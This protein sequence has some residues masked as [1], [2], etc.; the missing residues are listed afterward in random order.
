[1]FVNVVRDVQPLRTKAIPVPFVMSKNAP[2]LAA[3]TC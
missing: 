2:L 3:I 1:M